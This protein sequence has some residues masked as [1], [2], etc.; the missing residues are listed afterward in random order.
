[1]VSTP[2]KNITVDK[3]ESSPNRDENKK[4]L[5]PPLRIIWLA[6]DKILSGIE[7]YLFSSA[8]LELLLPNKVNTS[9]NFQNIGTVFLFLSL[10]DILKKGHGEMIL[11]IPSRYRICTFSI[12][13]WFLWNKC[14]YIYHLSTWMLWCLET[15]KLSKKTLWLYRRY[16]IRYPPWPGLKAES[17]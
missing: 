2:L 8:A 14:W 15:T 9:Q 13:T 5:K 6:L 7:T 10:K 16:R 17:F 11:P 1:M 3:W 12:F 4:P